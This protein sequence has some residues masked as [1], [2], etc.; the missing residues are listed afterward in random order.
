MVCACVHLGYLPCSEFS[1]KVI[2]VSNLSILLC[3]W[4]IYHVHNFVALVI[5]IMFWNL[6]HLWCLWSCEWSLYYY[7]LPAHLAFTI[8]IM[9]WIKQDAIWLSFLQSGI[10][11]CHL[12][13]LLNYYAI[14]N[15]GAM[16]H[17]SHCYFCCYTR[18][19]HSTQF[20][21][22][23]ST[24]CTIQHIV[25]ARQIFHFKNKR[26]I[27][28]ISKIESYTISSLHLLLHLLH[29]TNIAQIAYTM[30]HPT[31]LY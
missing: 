31:K 24:F 9:F 25:M 14:C 1:W 3:T 27:Y 20:I 5:F 10:I 19:Q 18:A 12:V 26:T 17:S 21:S 4:D 22:P 8:F 28:F 13:I 7:W 29:L 23:H 2:L 16:Q 6:W 15:V 11:S 30:Q